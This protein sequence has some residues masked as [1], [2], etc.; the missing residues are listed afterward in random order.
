MLALVGVLAAALVALASVAIWQAHDATRERAAEQVLGLARASTLLIDQEFA[1]AEALLHGMASSP[2]IAEGDIAAFLANARRLDRALDG[3]I[4]AYA[5]APGRQIANTMQGALATPAPMPGGLDA[6]FATGTT[7]ISNLYAGSVTGRPNVAIALPVLPPDGGPPRYAIGITLNRAALRDALSRQ[8]MPPGAVAAVLDRTGI[9]AARTRREEAVVGRHATQPVLDGLAMRDIGLIERIVNQDGEV[10]LV[11]FARAPRS[12]YAAVIAVPE[13]AFERERNIALVRLTSFAV[14]VVLGALLVALLL[15]LQLRS[16]LA[17]L[18][19]GTGG[20]RLAEVEELGAALAAA[21][22]ARQETEAAL[23]ERSAWLE[24]TQEAAEIGVWDLDLASGTLR[25]S[26]TMWRMF[27]LD[28]APD[29]TASTEEIRERIL[30]EDRERVEAALQAALRG[31]RYAAE[32]RIRRPDGTQRWIRARGTVERGADGTVLRLIGANLD[33]T[34]QRALEEERESL[35]AQKD[36]LVE[37][38][39]HRVKNSL[40][41][42]QGLLLLQARGAEPALAERLKEAAG[43]I[44]SIAAVHRRLYEGGQEPMQDVADHL[45]GLVEDLGRSLGSAG[46]RV[47]LEAEPG[48]RL[49]PERMAALGLLVTELVTNALKHGAGNV[50][51]RLHGPDPVV[52]VEDEGAGFPAAFDPAKSRGLGMR[53]AIAMARQLHGTLRAGPGARVTVRFP[54]RPT[55]PSREAPAANR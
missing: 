23:R 26:E 14:P 29:G 18:S 9:V 19:G 2:A 53:V 20:P 40:Q 4:M 46:R 28:P 30:A 15:A 47:L 36:L 3:L 7:T 41:L 42:V 27:G 5:E 34:G 55:S 52:E 33:I 8:H 48:M 54:I 50:T 17:G 1:R 44:L 39:H 49:P 16:A 24:Q 22:R 21:D 13:A 31:G 45:A 32:F 25:G 10:S 12:G 11:A 37:E 51:V 6:V 35:L 43:R 38:M